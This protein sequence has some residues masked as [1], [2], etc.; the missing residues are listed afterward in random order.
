M[1]WN[2]ITDSSCDLH[3]LSWKDNKNEI[4]FFSVPFIISVGEKDYID[5]EA[6][7][8]NELVDEMEKPENVSH[9]S[10]P[11]PNAWLDLFRMEGNIIAITISRELSGSY[12]SACVARDMLKEEQPDKNIAIVNS[13]S[14]GPGLAMQARRICANI[15]KGM[16]FSSV[17]RAAEA[18]MHAY[19]TIFALCSFNNL[20]KNGRMSPIIGFIARKLGFWGIGVASSIGTIEIVGKTRG[21]KKAL[22]H[23]SDDFQKWGKPIRHLIISHCQNPELAESLKEIVHAQWQNAIVEIHETRGLCSYYAERHGLI[24]TYC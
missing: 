4:R 13:I 9:T 2:I 19:R 8:I 1:I 15:Q 17:E 16:D 20:V 12:N 3:E 14:A 22:A 6:I 11:A 21:A 10:C 7:N 24:I 23:I 5:D 18:D